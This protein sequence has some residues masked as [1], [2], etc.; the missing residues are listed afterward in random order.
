MLRAATA[1]ALLA[2]FGIHDSIKA[3]ILV[4]V[5]DSVA[6]RYRSRPAVPARSRVSSCSRWAAP[7]PPRRPRVLVS[8]GSAIINVQHDPNAL[9]PWS[10]FALFAGYAIVTRAVSA[11]LLDRRDA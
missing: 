8:A 11:A 3:A 4:R 5:V 6:R 10:G 7:Q 2:A 9:A 1:F